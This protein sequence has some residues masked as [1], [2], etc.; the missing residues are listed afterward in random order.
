MDVDPL[1]SLLHQRSCSCQHILHKLGEN[2]KEEGQSYLGH[3]LK[4]MLYGF[5]LGAG[6]R[7]TSSTWSQLWPCKPAWETETS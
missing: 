1:T 7:S 4:P 5:T 3:A 6:H 2:G